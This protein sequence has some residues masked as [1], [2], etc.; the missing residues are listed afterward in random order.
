MRQ[1]RKGTRVAPLVL[2][3]LVPAVVYAQQ[4]PTRHAFTPA[5]LYK[6]TQVGAPAL[7]PDGD[8]V[9]FTVTTVK[10]AENRRHSEV[11]VVSTQGGEPARYTS[12]SFE[13]SAPRF[14]DDGK[15]LYFTSQR[16][17]RARRQ[18]G[19]SDGSGIWRSVPARS[20]AAVPIR[21]AAGG[22]ELHDHERRQCRWWRARWSRRRRSRRTRRLA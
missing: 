8:K 12:P 17:G 3:A 18:L 14:S 11:W 16:P 2:V 15:I 6:V 20:A 22:Q 21:I 5:D 19:A 10:E 4:T 1:H 7:S 13:S 9:A